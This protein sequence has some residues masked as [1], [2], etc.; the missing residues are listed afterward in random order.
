MIQRKGLRVQVPSIPKTCK[1]EN[2]MGFK[3]YTIKIARWCNGSMIG[4]NPIGQSSNLWRAELN[5]G[6]IAYEMTLI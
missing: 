6:G 4:P 3:I 1:L 5:N 2:N